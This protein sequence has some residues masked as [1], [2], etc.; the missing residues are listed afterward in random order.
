MVKIFEKFLIW[1]ALLLVG[2]LST[3]IFYKLWH[4]STIEW[5]ENENIVK[6][7]ISTVLGGFYGLS[8]WVIAHIFSSFDQ[9]LK[10]NFMV[11]MSVIIIIVMIVNLFI[12]ESWLL[13]VFAFSSLIGLSK[14]ELN[15]E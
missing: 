13:S 15:V 7:F 12:G 9:K 4:S 10:I 1:I 2:A 14:M 5:R 8:L 6:F 11:I 3:Y